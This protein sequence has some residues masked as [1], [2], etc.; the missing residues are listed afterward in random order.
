M[1]RLLTLFFALMAGAAF[2]AD[3]D[4][5]TISVSGIGTVEAPPDRATLNLSIVSRQATV[6]AAQKEASEV[7]ARVL[8]LTADMDIPDNQVDTMSATVRPNYRWNAQKEEQEL[9]GYIAERQLRIDVHDL[10]QVGEV[11]ERAVEAGVNQVAPPQ[12][13]SSRQRD[14]YR[15]ALE[16][17]T[18]DARMNAERIAESLGL[19]LGKAIQVN[20]GTPYQPPMPMG[21]VQAMGVDMSAPETYRA[22]DMSVSATVSVVFE[23]TN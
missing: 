3:G 19:T 2:A 18:A 12:L 17:A 13:M 14:A 16:R 15:D 1:S 9:H 8:T 7:T 4:T 20:A 6:A 10:Q 22:G 23:T 11:I 21:R 5:N